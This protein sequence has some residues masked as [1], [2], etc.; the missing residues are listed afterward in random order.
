MKLLV[1]PGSARPNSFGKVV[2]KYVEQAT[3][4]HDVEIE[5]VDTSILAALPY[6]DASFPPSFDGYTI[7]HD[8]VQ[9]WSDMVT[10]ADA[11]LLVMPE[12]NHGLTAIQ[13]NALDWLYGEWKDKPLGIVTY[14]FYGGAHALTAFSA[15][16]D[17]IKTKLI[18]PITQITFGKEVAPDGTVTDEATITSSI[19]N[20]V[21]A[22][23]N[24]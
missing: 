15:V 23:I 18:E 22:L 24:G 9:K 2:E 4:S 13:K 1:V 17:N 14:G 10:A 19:K 8:S 5:V 7:P 11:V 3:A 12:Y 20:T 16:N 21:D 6:F